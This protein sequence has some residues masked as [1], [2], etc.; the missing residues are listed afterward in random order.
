MKDKNI[1]DSFRRFNENLNI[2]DVMNSSFSCD[3]YITDSGLGYGEY[4]YLIR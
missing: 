4:A 3:V 2:S 1:I